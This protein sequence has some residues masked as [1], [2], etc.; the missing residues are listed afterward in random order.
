MDYGRVKLI[1]LLVH[2]NLIATVM[3]SLVCSQHLV[4]KRKLVKSH[5]LT[6]LE[7]VV[8]IPPLVLWKEYF[9]MQGHCTTES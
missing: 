7:E 1:T 5:L 6:L 3:L 8:R 2:A 9:F 4:K